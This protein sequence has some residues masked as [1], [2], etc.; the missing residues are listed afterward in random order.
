MCSSVPIIQSIKENL[1]NTQRILVWL[2]A[3]T[4]TV[5]ALGGC[6]PAPTPPTAVPPAAAPTG[7]PTA[8]ALPATATPAAITVTDSANR[9]VTIAAP[10]QRI[11]SLAPSTTE[12][13]FALGLG[14]RI[15][16]V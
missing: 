10:P 14:N 3:L 5:L 11:V 4:I 8:T 6:A 16:A 13:A 1:M 9:T 12:I 7:V 15:V 2:I